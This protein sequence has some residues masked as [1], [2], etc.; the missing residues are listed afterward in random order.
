MAITKK[1]LTSSKTT[2]KSPKKPSKATKPAAS[3]KMTTA[4]MFK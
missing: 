2:A 4:I 3:T 1:S